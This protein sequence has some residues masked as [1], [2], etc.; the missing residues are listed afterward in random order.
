MEVKGNRCCLHNQHYSLKSLD[1]NIGVWLFFF[2]NLFILFLASMGLRCCLRAFFWLQRAGA[3]LRCGVQA[4][5]CGLLLLGAWVL[6]AWASVVA[7]HGLSSCGA[8][9]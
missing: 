8:G 1:P 2:F 7:A 3:T 6:G 9:A 4:S 5:H